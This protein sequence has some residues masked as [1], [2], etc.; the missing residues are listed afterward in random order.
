MLAPRGIK[1][2]RRPFEV[3]LHETRTESFVSTS[4]NFEP[5]LPVARVRNSD[6]TRVGWQKE[7]N[8]DATAHSRRQMEDPKNQLR[9]K[10][11]TNTRINLFGK[12][13]VRVSLK[14]LHKSN[15]SCQFPLVS[16]YFL[17]H[18]VLY[19]ENTTY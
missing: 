2:F 14:E 4:K 9:E 10:S 11:F 16:N 17:H 5:G 15:L 7:Q 13:R 19:V 8:I 3:L 18:T 6:F 1:V 12:F